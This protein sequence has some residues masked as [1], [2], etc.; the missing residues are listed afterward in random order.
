MNIYNFN[1]VLTGK[2][3]CVA[4]GNFDGVHTGHKK[5]ISAAVAYARESGLSSCVYTFDSHPTLTLGNAKP[6]ITDNSEKAEIIRK[7]GCDALY[8]ECFE[9]VR[10]LSPKEFC[11]RILKDKLNAE[12]VFCGE[13]HR[14]GYKG[15]GTVEDLKRELA[16]L[17]IGVSVIPY[18]TYEGEIISSSKIR[19]LIEDG[20]I[21]VATELLGQRY[22]VSGTV[23]HG[24][25]LGRTLGF[26]TLNIPV[27]I[28]R[29]TPKFGVYVTECLLDGVIYKGVSNIGI[30]PTTDSETENSR[31][32][33]CETYL[34]GFSGDAYG[35]EIT[36]YFNDFIRP[37]MKFDS[38]EALKERIS[39]DVLTA[40]EYFSL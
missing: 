5:I 15:S 1:T 19:T 18:A 33:N 4:L 7:L 21:K 29:V 34:M 10:E 24:K 38:V 11:H 23:M 40:K 17:G 25:K 20:N 31:L 16:P 8:Y 36:V 9:S 32:V 39:E 13:N 28:G 2:K 26:P 6:I 14:F 30:R 35:K 12:C 27:G 22:S 3:S 37:E